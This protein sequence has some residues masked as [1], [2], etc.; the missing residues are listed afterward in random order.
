VKKTEINPWLELAVQ[1]TL[2]FL[3]SAGLIVAGATGNNWY[4]SAPIV[5]G[6]IGIVFM[7]VTTPK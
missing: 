4:F 6:L 2:G 3:M 7:R 5:F 1:V